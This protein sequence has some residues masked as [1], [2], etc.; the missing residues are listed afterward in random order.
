MLLN[1]LLK[2]IDIVQI[3][4]NNNPNIMGIKFNSK[5]VNK[6]DIFVCLKGSLNGAEYLNEAVSKG[7]V[8]CVCE[9]ITD[10]LI[11]Q[12]VVKSARKTLSLMCKNFYGAACDDFK[13]IMVTGTN[14][15]TSVSYILNSILSAS[16]LKSAIIGTNGIFYDN[17]QLYYGLTTPD[18]TELHFYFS[19]L[20]KMG[21]TTIVMEASAHAIKLCKLEGISAEQI[22]FTNLTNEHLDYFK[23]ME[24]YSQTKLDYICKENTNMAI[25]NAD[26]DYGVKLLKKDLPIISYGL[27]NPADTFAVEITNSISGVNFCA[28][29]MDEIIEIESNLIGLY[30]VYNILASITSALCLGVSIKNIKLGLKNLKNIPGR[31]NKFFLDLNNLVV[32]DF[33]H[34]PDGFKN[35]LGEIKSLRG[36]RIITLF[37]CV[38]YSDKNKRVLM[39][40]IASSYSDELVLTADNINFESFDEIC[41]DITKNVSV[42]V[43]KI[44]NRKEAVEFAFSKLKK[45][46][47]LLLLGKGCETSNLIKGVKVPYSDLQT[48][49]ECIEKFYNVKKGENVDNCI[50]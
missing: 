27:K 1:N 49:E 26:D 42:P 44:F 48:V 36:G 47:T 30:N 31:F 12:V 38:G 9:E 6:G 3:A 32:V 46:D 29:V 15:K 34:T 13:I 40:E 22:I 10:V 19:E 45:N 20:K 7:A 5:E 21:V 50:I 33:A 2:N 37:G 11:P 25:V 17:K 14:G 18:P 35:I 8:A 23:T 43:T 24:E 16:G 39:G 4:N 28:N 41:D